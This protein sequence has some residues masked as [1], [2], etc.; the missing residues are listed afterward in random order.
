MKAIIFNSGLGNRMGEFTKQNHKSMAMLKNGETI[1]ERQLRILA[2]CGLRDFI[3]TTGPFK[4]QLEQ[5]CSKEQFSHLN[6]NFV[7]N[8]IYDKTNYIYSM[9][10]AREH[11]ND[12]ALILHGDLVFDK[13]LIE[14]ILK[15]DYK[16]LATASMSK[17]LPKKDFKARIIAGNIREV[18]VNIFDSNCFAFQPLYKL[19]KDKL[20][21]WTKKVEEY[22]NA[23]ND[24]VYAENAL[25][26][27]LMDLEI[28]AFEYESF[29]IDEVDN[30]EDL[31][32]VSE[33][34][35]QFDFDE[36]E[37]MTDTGDYIKIPRVE[38]GVGMGH[39]R[40]NAGLTPGGRLR[41]EK[42]VSL[43][44]TKKLDVSKLITHKFTGFKEVEPALMLM[45]DKPADLIKPVVVIE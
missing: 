18:S 41:M 28:K 6:F 3:I 44:E 11:F 9:Y 39:K 40:I 10:L 20:K 26:E 19:S 8:P 38:W 1:L 23:G 24:K 30:L 17:P 5:V 45:K 14:E 31:A 12:D 13:K 4:E 42:L 15:C 36:Q 22:I 25:N 33:E 34:I 27:L 29:Y 37:I 2:E 16:S 7:N 32:R 43:V 21:A 35:R